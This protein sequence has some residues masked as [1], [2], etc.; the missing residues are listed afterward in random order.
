MVY[1]VRACFLKLFHN[2]VNTFISSKNRF[3]N[4]QKKFFKSLMKYDSIHIYMK[5]YAQLV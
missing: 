5:K 3:C 2:A 4:H 1:I